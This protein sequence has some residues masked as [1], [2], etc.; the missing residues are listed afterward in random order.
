MQVQDVYSGVYD[1]YSKPQETLGNECGIVVNSANTQYHGEWTCKVFVVG[2][3]L[4]GT[5]HVVVTSKYP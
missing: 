5:K 2:K 3:S 4:I 1:Y